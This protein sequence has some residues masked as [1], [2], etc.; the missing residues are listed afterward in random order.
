MKP[1]SLAGD[2]AGTVSPATSSASLGAYTALV[3]DATAVNRSLQGT[4]DGV[5]N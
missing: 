3:T 5:L 2:G 4:A 1:A